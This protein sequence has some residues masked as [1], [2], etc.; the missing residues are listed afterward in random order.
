MTN[1]RVFYLFFIYDDYDD[2]HHARVYN[3]LKELK[4]GERFLID[5]SS[6]PSSCWH[7][8]A[9]LHIHANYLACIA[10]QCRS[11]Y[12]VVLVALPDHDLFIYLVL[13]ARWIIQIDIYITPIKINAIYIYTHNVY[14]YCT[15][16]HP[17]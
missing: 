6:S 5:S 13:Q 14:L 15:W 1:S 7:D 4:L 10:S 3:C 9:I 2:I 12:S 11:H 17:T 16:M 8:C